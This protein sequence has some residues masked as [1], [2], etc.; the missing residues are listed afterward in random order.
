MISRNKLIPR[1]SAVLLGT[2]LAL[3]MLEAG[4]RLAGFSYL[5][6]QEYRNR[7]AL[8]GDGEVRILC[9]GDSMTEGQYPR[10]LEEI[11]NARLDG[12]RVAVFDEGR[13]GT[14]SGYVVSI[15]EDRLDKYDPHIVIIMM[16]FNDYGDKLPY[17]RV[18]ISRREPLKTIRLLKVL[19]YHV[20]RHL[21]TPGGIVA[22]RRASRVLAERAR[23]PDTAGCDSVGGVHSAGPGAV[24]PAIRPVTAAAAKLHE[25]GSI[26]RNA[27]RFT[28]AERVFRRI[29]EQNPEDILACIRLGLVSID[30]NLPLEVER[31][32]ERA[33]ELDPG[34]VGVYVELSRW[35]RS[36]PVYDKTERLLLRAIDENPGCVEGYDEL[37]RWYQGAG[38][39]EE[40]G[41]VF[42][43][44]AALNPVY[45]AYYHQAGWRPV[46]EEM[47]VNSIDSLS[48][49][50]EREPGNI[51]ALLAFSNMQQN[52]F[53][54]FDMI[55]KVLLRGLKLNP[56]SMEMHLEIA[57]WYRGAGRYSDAEKM[58][59][60]AVAIDP[61]DVRPY[62]VMAVCAE[63]QKHYDVAEKAYRRI[64]TLAP[65]NVDGF[66]QLARLYCD[67]NDM[68]LAEETLLAC[69]EANPGSSA[70]A[71]HLACWYKGRFD[72]SMA[73]AENGSTAKEKAEFYIGRAIELDPSNPR[74]YLELADMAAVSGDCSRVEGL[75]MKA[76]EA[77]PEFAAAHFDLSQ[78]LW[79]RGEYRRS[80]RFLETAVEL[81]PDN[82]YFLPQRRVRFDAFNPVT[83]ENFQDCREMVS[84]RGKMLVLVQYPT[85][86]VSILERLIGD[87]REGI[88]FVDNEKIFKEAVASGTFDEYFRDSYG[89]TFGHCTAKGNR[90]LAGSIADE[91]T[92]RCF[93]VDG[94]G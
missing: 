67:R 14:E 1:L 70:A 12:K 59:R 93:S 42:E 35:Y 60:S 37:A 30:L 41:R 5:S 2:I 4:I 71:S 81:N 56:S 68:K 90:L 7:R 23:Q 39:Y 22:Q 51:E 43:A 15:L 72:L 57:E 32:F 82:D 11:L 44:A 29:L 73:R 40:A 50:V 86:P 80:Y 61:G 18:P 26:L 55:E 34:N 24:P 8:A 21:T 87:D 62:F 77:D 54:V 45:E 75:L 91:I 84:G 9:L 31:N 66:C 27:G 58:I 33:I 92:A 38:R 52:H 17:G 47:I 94:E 83:R 28:E 63:I 36:I 6:V 53:E 76:I 20:D 64:I 3:A 69:W 49:V 25:E 19:K 65:D 85:V 88:V 74:P 13:I 10:P 79:N 78:W 89:T 46:Q 16:G 48:F